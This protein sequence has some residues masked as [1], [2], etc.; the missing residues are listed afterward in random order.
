MRL[1]HNNL[2]IQTRVIV[3]DCNVVAMETRIFY[4]LS[5]TSNK[6]VVSC[7][8]LHQLKVEGLTLYYALSKSMPNPD[9]WGTGR[10]LWDFDS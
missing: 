1:S 7:S 6:A 8:Y 4:T 3:L 5:P 2:Y 9:L 10:D